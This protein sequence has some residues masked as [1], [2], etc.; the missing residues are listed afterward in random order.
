MLPEFDQPMDREAIRNQLDRILRSESFADK[1]QLQKL[2]EVL[3]NHM[4]S[5]ASLKPDRVIREL[6]P[7][8]TKTKGSADVATEMNRLRRALES[9][10]NGEGKADP[11][12]ISLPNR[13][14]PAP[15]GLQET[16]WIAA[17]PREGEATRP[18]RA[19][20][21]QRPIPQMSARRS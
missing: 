9:Y 11:I 12:V 6:W 13:S 1:D 20:K 2:L 19:N 5:P 10:Y 15:D 8:E 7:E 3:F 21:D 14:A 4:D 18:Q 17:N 16:R